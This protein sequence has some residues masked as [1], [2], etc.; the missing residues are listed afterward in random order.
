MGACGCGEG[1]E[2]HAV[3]LP[4]GVIVAY[5]VYPGCEDCHDGLGFS[6]HFYDTEEGYNTYACTNRLD[7]ITPDCDGGNDGFGL[8][9]R[10]FGISELVEAAACLEADGSR[11]GEDRDNYET[12][13]EWMQDNGLRLIQDAIRRHAESGTS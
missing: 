10:A 3:K 13:A 1:I 9:L 5:G 8:A 4:N 12:I 2:D 7:E 6:M 11:V